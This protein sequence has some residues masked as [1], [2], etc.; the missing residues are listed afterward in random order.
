M[1]GKLW[2]AAL[3]GDHDPEDQRHR[4]EGEPLDR[5]AQVRAIIEFRGIEPAGKAG[6]GGIR[7]LAQIDRSD[8]IG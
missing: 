1:Q 6:Q 5:V 7:Q 8:R 4:R 3:P 2:A